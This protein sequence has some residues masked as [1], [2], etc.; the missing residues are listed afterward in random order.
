MDKKTFRLVHQVAR[1]GA[2]EAVRNAPEGWHV[3]IKPPTRSL[4]ANARMWALLGDISAQV[5]WHGRKLS[6]EDWKYVFSSSLRKLDVV[7]NI[8][9]SGFVALGLSTSQF[10]VKEMNDL[11]MIIEAFGAQ[12]GVEFQKWT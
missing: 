1:Q 3:T 11:Q 8:E 9:G 12:Q 2:T 5:V 4:D 6:P 10:T 7:P